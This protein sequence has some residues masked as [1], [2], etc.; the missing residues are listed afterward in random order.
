MFTWVCVNFERGNVCI[1]V[2][3]CPSAC[4]Q[5]EDEGGEKINHVESKEDMFEDATDDMDSNGTQQDQDYDAPSSSLDEFEGVKT[6]L[7]KTVKEKESIA[8]EFKV[9]PFCF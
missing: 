8:N 1:I 7:D 9:H 2:F 4:M 3:M 5:E 6:L